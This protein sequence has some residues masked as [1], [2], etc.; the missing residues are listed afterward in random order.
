MIVSF[1]S[2]DRVNEL[3]RT[4]ELSYASRESRVQ[5]EHP[6]VCLRLMDKHPPPFGTK[7]GVGESVDMGSFTYYGVKS[8]R[9]A[10]LTRGRH[11]HAYI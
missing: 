8:I 3:E 6:L 9:N 2:V 10:V 1:L 7:V 4:A 11:D 5:R